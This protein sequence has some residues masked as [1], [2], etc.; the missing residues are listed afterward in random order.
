VTTALVGSGQAAA[1]ALMTFA[2]QVMAGG[3]MSLIVT[4]NE[5]LAGLPDASL[6]VQLTVVVPFGKAVPDGGEQDGEPTPEQLSDTVGAAYIT[7]AVQALA[8]VAFIIAAGQVIE[9]GVVS[10]ALTTTGV[11]A[12][13]VQPLAVT[14]TV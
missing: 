3:C 13:L 11:E 12:A 5:Q 14:L 2:G 8:S 6:T 10:L 4:V 7:T 1:A 9:G